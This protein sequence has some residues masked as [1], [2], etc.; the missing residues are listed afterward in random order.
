MSGNDLL[1]QRSADTNVVWTYTRHED[2]SMTRVVGY[3]R[4]STREQA[5]SGAGLAAQRSA[6]AA[7]AARRGWDVVWE[8]DAGQSGKSLKR[9]GITETLRLLK[10]REASALVVAKLDRL[11]RSVQDFAGLLAL[12]GKQGWAVVALDLGVDTTTPS[13]RLVAHVLAAVAEWERDVIGQ[14]T[15]DALAERKAAGMRLGRER[16]CSPATVARIVASSEAGLTVAA[17]AHALDAERVPTP[18]GGRRWYPS[19]V[20]RLLIAERA[21]EAT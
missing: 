15:R 3:L 17:I 21:R 18:R 20:R 16:M 19:T 8:E 13:G 1:V 9:P 10:R 5:D 7:E 6:I 12:A 11:S 2:G 14:R 4:V